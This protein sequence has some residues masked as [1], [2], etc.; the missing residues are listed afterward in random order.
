MRLDEHAI[1]THGVIPPRAPSTCRNERVYFRMRGLSD[2][3]I[4]VNPMGKEQ[5]LESQVIESSQPCRGRRQLARRLGSALG[6]WLLISTASACSSARSY[7]WVDD[8]VAKGLAAA[9]RLIR[10][11]DRIHLLVRGQEQLSAEADVRP[12]GEVVVPVVGSVSAA[13]KSPTE[14][15]NAIAA[16]LNGIVNA[17]VVTVVVERRR[18]AVTLLGEVRAPGRY[19]LDSRDGVADALAR[20]GGLTPFADGDL[21]FV[22]RRDPH[23]AR[24]RLRYDD[25]TGAEKVTLGFELR[26]GDI[27]VVE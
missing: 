4:A 11:G 18:T 27:V 26:D 23:L 3:L 21:V 15:A 1:E 13:S 12:D 5:C 25:L 24:I 2:I 14:L 7:V 17:P 19:E 22:I 16:R 6:C 20:A 8:Y 9:P 10:P